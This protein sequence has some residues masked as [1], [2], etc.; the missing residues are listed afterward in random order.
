MLQNSQKNAQNNREIIF[1][2]RKKILQIE[3][4]NAL[5]L[6]HRLKST[7]Y[8]F[9]DKVAWMEPTVRSEE[10]FQKM[11]ILAFEVSVQ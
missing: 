4:N 7:F 8:D 5:L 3:G 10:I 6:P 11:L 9:F 2:Q 1:H